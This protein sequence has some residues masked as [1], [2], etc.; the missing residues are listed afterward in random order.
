MQGAVWPQRTRHR[1]SL[2]PKEREGHDHERCRVS[3]YELVRG[4]ARQWEASR[5]LDVRSWPSE[6]SNRN[7]AANLWT[8]TTPHSP[9]STTHTHTGIAIIV[10]IIKVSQQTR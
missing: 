8:L 5:T 4:S 9:G 7:S 1:G 6:P 3:T 10:I 2:Q